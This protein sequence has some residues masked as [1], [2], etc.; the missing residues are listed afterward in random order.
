MDDDLKKGVIKIT[1]I[2]LIEKGKT[3]NT[4]KEYEVKIEDYTKGVHYGIPIKKKDGT[5]TAAYETFKAKKI[6][7]EEKFINNMSVEIGIG[8]NEKVIGWEHE[9]KSGEST[10]RTIRFLSNANEIRNQISKEG[11]M[12]EEIKKD[13]LDLDDIP[14]N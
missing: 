1:S 7:W 9:G 8:Y 10:Y 3:P 5:F 14:F 2:D 4:W 6:E 12:E 11:I 13:N